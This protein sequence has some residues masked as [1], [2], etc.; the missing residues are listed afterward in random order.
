MRQYSQ[1]LESAKLCFALEAAQAFAANPE[2]STYSSSGG[3]ERG[4]FLAIRWGMGG[5]CVAVVRIDE[6][7]D[8]TNYVQ[9]IKKA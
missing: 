6:N 5:D 7:D 4:E 9:F 8:P 3:L 1:T 2:I